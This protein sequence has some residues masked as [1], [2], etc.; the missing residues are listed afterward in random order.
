MSTT[1][2]ISLI[3]HNEEQSL[4]RC[5]DS[6]QRLADEI[7]VMDT[8]DPRSQRQGRHWRING[9]NRGL[10]SPAR[11]VMCVLA[12][13]RRRAHWVRFVLNIA[14]FSKTSDIF[15]LRFHS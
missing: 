13:G 15:P 4:G 5:L 3:A 11:Q 1:L 14:T 8:G 9:I 12:S 10:T 7:V 6:V 2:T